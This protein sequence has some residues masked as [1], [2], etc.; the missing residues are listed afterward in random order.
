MTDAERSL[1][2]PFAVI[3]SVAVGELAMDDWSAE[4]ALRG[5]VRWC[6]AGDGEERPECGEPSRV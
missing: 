6:D 4:R 3:G 1:G 2:E 5:I